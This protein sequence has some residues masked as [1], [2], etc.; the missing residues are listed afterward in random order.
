MVR[1]SRVSTVQADC[2]SNDLK[3]LT[4]QNDHNANFLFLS[5]K[6]GLL[7]NFIHHNWPS[8]LKLPFLEEFITP[9]V[10]VKKGQQKHS[11]YSLPEFQEWKDS[12]RDWKSWNV[13]YYKGLGTSTSEEAKEYFTNLTRNRIKFKYEGIQDDQSIEL[14]FSKKMVEDRKVWLTNSM[15]DRKRRR[16]LGLPEVY[17][18]ERDTREITYRDFINKELILFSN[19]DNERSIPSLMDGL[20]PGQR[21]VLFTCFKRNDTK[22]VKVAQLAA[23]VGEK[24]AYHHGEVS[25]QT[26]IVGLAQDYVG[27]NNIA[28]L[29]PIGQFGTRLQGGKDCASARYIFTML[30]PLARKLFPADDDPL[31]NYL[32]DDNLRIEPEYYVPI[33]PTVLVNGA[34]GIGTG[35]STNIPNYNPR[36]LAENIKRLLK[37]EELQELKP[38]FKDFRGSIIQLDETR[39]LTVGEMA[40]LDGNKFEITE[41]PIRTWTQTY[42]E[43]VL[44]PYVNGSDKQPVCISEYK[45]Y[46]TDETVRFVITMNEGQA[47]KIRDA[48]YYKHFKLQSSLSTGSMVLFDYQGVL[49]KYDSPLAILREFFEVRKDFYYRRKQYLE[50]KF[51]AETSRL[52]NQA[53][54]ILENIAEDFALVKM[55]EAP[56]IR[57]LARRGYD[58]DPEKEWKKRHSNQYSSEDVEADDADPDR[59]YDFDYLLNMNIRTLLPDHAEKL[60]KKRDE[61]QKELNELRATRPETFWIRDLD[62]FLEELDKYERVKSEQ[63]EKGHLAMKN[64][65]KSVGKKKHASAET[66]P[67]EFGER[68]EPDLEEEIAKKQ[69]GKVKKEKKFDFKD[70]II[71][72]D[73]DIPLSERIGTSPEMIEKNKKIS[74]TTNGESKLLKQTKLNFKPISKPKDDDLMEVDDEDV[75]IVEDRNGDENSN[76]LATVSTDSS[77]EP[78]DD[79][80]ELVASSSRPVATSSSAVPVKKPTAV[81]EIKPKK[82]KEPKEKKPKEPKKPKEKKEPKK[83]ARKNSDSDDSFSFERKKPKKA[84]KGSDSDDSFAVKKKKPKKARKDSDSDTDDDYKSNEIEIAKELLPFIEKPERSKRAAAATVKSKYTFSSDENTDDDDFA[85]TKKKKV[86]SDSDD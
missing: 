65:F 9:I 1:T 48:G 38:W 76:G 70:E 86:D 45:E 11:F 81:K 43:N 40:R 18:Y 78:L 14:A 74:A 57:E 26:T 10:K 20:K 17:L 2:H 39:Y 4:A 15:E 56:L 36:E 63:I 77:V 73:E 28:L 84:R 67:S 25:L 44:E 22:E 49:R 24:S 21:K 46:H 23:S 60:S 61:K 72:D 64:K 85:F 82:P 27:S 69:A 62:A 12:T 35:W 6:K 54:F 3:V 79:L 66:K 34:T 5:N 52:S 29:Q 30:S 31:L 75:T 42:K 41:L 59:E 7:I 8:L 68:I 83:K 16:E 47:T 53:R 58:S 33:I 71:L 13:K 19:A 55:K 50:G 80:G 51:E 32:W 37:G